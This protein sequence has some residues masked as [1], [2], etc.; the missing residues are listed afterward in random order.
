MHTLRGLC[1]M[2]KMVPTIRLRPNFD[3]PSRRWAKVLVRSR[4]RHV[5]KLTRPS[6][7]FGKV[8]VRPRPRH[9]VVR[10]TFHWQSF[11]IYCHGIQRG[12]HAYQCHPRN[13]LSPLSPPRAKR[14]S[15]QEE[16]SS[17]HG[18]C[19][20]PTAT[21]WKA[22]SSSTSVVGGCAKAMGARSCVMRMGDALIRA[23]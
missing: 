16:P 3:R 5:Q 20:T 19:R 6:P 11:A 12:G 9:A 18:Q 10:G 13:A 22:Q 4:P 15:S 14:Y 2:L 8:L 1:I 21:P 7:C 17:T 23:A